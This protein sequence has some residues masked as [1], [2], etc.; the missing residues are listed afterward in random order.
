MATVEPIHEHRSRLVGFLAWVSVA[1]MVAFLIVALILLAAV[2]HQAQTSDRNDC[3]SN[4]TQAE[5]AVRDVRD[6]LEAQVIQV[7]IGGGIARQSTPDLADLNARLGTAV[8]DVQRLPKVRTV[9]DHGGTI[10]RVRY[11]ACPTA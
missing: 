9:V 2:S 10:D 11:R 8:A 1:G 3:R 4:I 6:N 5:Q 7:I